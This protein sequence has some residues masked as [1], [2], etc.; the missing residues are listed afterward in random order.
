MASVKGIL[1]DLGVSS[2]QLDSAERG[3]SYRFDA[4]LD[5][6]MDTRDGITA[7]DVL[8]QYSAVELQRVFGE[9]G[10]GAQL[11]NTRGSSREI[12]ESQPIEIRVNW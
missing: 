4:A 5:M 11:K 9:L 1:A 7:A 3:F 10:E 6:R 2:H 12:A 8:N